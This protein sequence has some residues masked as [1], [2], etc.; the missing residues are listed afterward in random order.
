MMSE[1]AGGEDAEADMCGVLPM[2]RQR[3]GEIVHGGRP[4]HESY[5]TKRRLSR[6]RG[7][8]RH[9]DVA[10]ERAFVHHRQ[11]HPEVVRMLPV[12]ERLTAVGLAALQQQRV[13]TVCDRRGVETQHRSRLESATE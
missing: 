10:R 7:V 12:H 6:G 9:A 8:D 3:R 2:V 4:M 5:G 13:P 11:F 1:N